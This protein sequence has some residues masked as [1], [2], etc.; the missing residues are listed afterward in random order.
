LFVG[1]H[2][3]L[4]GSDEVLVDPVHEVALTGCDGGHPPHHHVQVLYFLVDLFEQC[5]SVVG[6][7]RGPRCSG[8]R[9]GAGVTGGL[10][11]AL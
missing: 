3:V 10:E 2:H 5:V 8:G 4:F 9:A 7:G 1:V 11:S 6:V